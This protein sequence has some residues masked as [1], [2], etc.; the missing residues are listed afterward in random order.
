MY[1]I[2]VYYI[3]IWFSSY[4]GLD[5][6]SENTDELKSDDEEI[7]DTSDVDGNFTEEEIEALDDEVVLTLPPISKFQKKKGHELSWIMI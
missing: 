1:L 5:Y 3:S 6:E 7:A 2:V 4:L